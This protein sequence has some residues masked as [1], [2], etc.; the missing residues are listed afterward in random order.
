M[1][2]GCAL[3]RGFKHWV[4]EER[5]GKTLGCREKNRGVWCHTDWIGIP[6]WSLGCVSFGSHIASLKGYG[7]SGLEI[8]GSIT[9]TSLAQG[10]VWVGFFSEGAEQSTGRPRYEGL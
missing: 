2:T 1:E 10:P 5:T 3:E 4:G 8:C 9:P 7:A 6:F